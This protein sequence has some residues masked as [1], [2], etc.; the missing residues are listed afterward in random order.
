M[1]TQPQTWMKEDINKDASLH[2]ENP[3]R[4]QLYTKKIK[5]IE[6]S[7]KLRGGVIPPHKEEHTNWQPNARWSAL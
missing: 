4:P 5:D 6:N 7:V 3:R 2:E 1:S